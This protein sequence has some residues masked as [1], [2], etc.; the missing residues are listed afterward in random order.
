MQLN[1]KVEEESK[2]L[3]KINVQHAS[4]D[5]FGEKKGSDLSEGQGGSSND[6][7]SGSDNDSD[8]DSDSSYSGSRSDSENDAS[9]KG[10]E[11]SDEDGEKESKYNTE[12][13]DKRV[14]VLIPVKPADG[15]RSLHYEILEKWDDNES[16]AVKTEKNLPEEQEAEMSLTTATSNKGGKVAED[17][18]FSPYHKQLQECQNYIGNLFDE[19]ENGVKDS[20]RH[21]QFDHCERSSKGKHKRDYDVKNIDEKA[22]QIKRSAAENF[23]QARGSP[24]MGVHMFESSHS[25]TPVGFTKDTFKQSHPQHL[26]AVNVEIGSQNKLAE[27]S[28]RLGSNESEVSQGIELEVRSESNSPPANAY[29]QDLPK[30]G[31]VQYPVKDSKRQTPN[32]LE[33]VADS[34]KSSGFADKNNSDQNRR[35]SSSDEDSCPYLKYEKDKPE[36]KGPIMTFSQ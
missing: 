22:E 2:T 1:S 31:I 20:S 9:S 30:P 26:K 19:R 16:D 12:L 11:G 21:Q 32:S 28:G 17:M 13:S 3:E 35:E 23:G 14:S 18:P 25:F 34:G 5:M 6:G 33:E 27:M 7:E 4:P 29:E 8:S 36:L 10:K 24:C 15:R